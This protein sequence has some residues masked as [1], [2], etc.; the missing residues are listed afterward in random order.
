MRQIANG[1]SANG[2]SSVIE[3]VSSEIGRHRDLRGFV[4]G[5]F[6]GASVQFKA[7]P[8][9]G[10]TWFDV[11]SAVSAKGMVELNNLPEHVWLKASVTGIVVAAD[12]DIWVG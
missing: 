1:L 3:G 2:D 6:D 7:S 12:L 9:G 8:D 5:T 11:G 10:T 4:S